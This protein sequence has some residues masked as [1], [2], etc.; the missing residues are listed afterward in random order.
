M[1]HRII[2]FDLAVR[3][4]ERAMAFYRAV[5]ATDVK[6]EFEGVGVISHDQGDVA[7]CLYV[8]DTYEPSKHG[9]LLYFNVDGRL[10]HAV[11][12]VTDHGGEIEQ[13][14]HEI[15]PFGRRAVA[16]DS[17]GNRIVLHSG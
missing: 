14:A 5:L 1:P 17:E 8:S 12:Q 3:D 7:G 9:A 16:I 13:P 15:G 2:W 6:E 4:L 10:E 11:Q